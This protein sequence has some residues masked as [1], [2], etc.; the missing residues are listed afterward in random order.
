MAVKKTDSKGNELFRG[1]R[2]RHDG[3]YEYRYTDHRG[4]QHS[5]YGYRLQQLRMEE[6]TIA[7][8]EHKGLLYG[9]K[10]LSLN[11]VFDMWIAGKGELKDNTLRGYRQIY[12]SYV[13]NGLG[14]RSI[15][16]IKTQ[17]IKLYYSGLKL[18]RSLSVE[19]ICRL[20]NILFQVFQY[21]YDSELIWKNPAL[22]ATKELRRSH[23]KRVSMRE[24]L[25]EYEAERLTDFILDSSKF[26]DWYPMIY[27][28]IHTGLRLGEAISLRWCDVNLCDRYIDVN[29]NVTYY[30]KEGEKAKHHASDVT[31]TVAGM[32]KIP[33][34]N[35][36]AEAFEMEREILIR[37]GIK[38]VQEIDGYM[39]FVFLNKNGKLFSQESIN[40]VLARIVEEYNCSINENN[41]SE[42][43]L[44]HITCHSLRHTYA[45]ILCE[46]DVNIKVMQ[47]LLGH[48]DIST[49][50][51]IYT[52]VSQNF[53]LKEYADKMK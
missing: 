46:R 15:E 43:S 9:L 2:E 36:V 52:R 40:R 29:H 19:T 27:I 14:K 28:M 45:T 48:K 23:P 41:A 42:R 24:G 38:S 7:Y 37:K 18:E 53:V 21:A 5:I 20:Q 13:R 30:A 39:D 16:D 31:K 3:R 4:Q 11:N 47:Y 44:P 34:D 33:I 32:R 22:R 49:T 8:R 17:D 10:E 1:E 50:M 12:D 35:K 6:A 25:N 51:D 26:R